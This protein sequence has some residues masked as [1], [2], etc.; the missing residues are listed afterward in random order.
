MR[1]YYELEY[2]EIQNL[3]CEFEKTPG[4]HRAEGVKKCIAIIIGIL[5]LIGASVSLYTVDNS[6]LFSNIF[7]ICILSI[8]LALLIICGIIK[9]IFY[10]KPFISWLRVK[11]KIEK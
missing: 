3:K 4:G 6:T 2:V 9:Y 5:C 1:S 7:V 10:D 8:L 11:K